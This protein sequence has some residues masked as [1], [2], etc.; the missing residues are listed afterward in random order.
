MPQSNQTRINRRDFVTA[1][2]VAAGLGVLAGACGSPPALGQT[3]QP[4]TGAPLDVGL[5]SDFSKDGP[6]MT[7]ARSKHVIIMRADDKLYAMSSR[8]THKGCVVKDADG[9]LHCPC[10]NSDFN[11]D[12]TVID[13]PAEGGGPIGRFGIS[14]NDAAH[15]LVD[16]TK[17][18]AED[19]W[20]DP[21]SFIALGA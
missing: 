14:L 6:T 20:S 4:S 17:K 15:V 11:Y 10:H 21:G 2:A 8:C 1:A 3:T 12:G 16:V 7:W 13:G 9:S 18:F 19:Q 5:K